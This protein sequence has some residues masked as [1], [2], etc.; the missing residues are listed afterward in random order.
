MIED[1]KTC[2][3]LLLAIET[4]SLL[5]PE[6]RTDGIVKWTLS[7]VITL[8]IILPIFGILKGFTK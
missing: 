7:L 2:F 1:F 4:A 5:L 8:S 6:G 3:I